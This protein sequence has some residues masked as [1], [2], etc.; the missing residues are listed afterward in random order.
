MTEQSLRGHLLLSAPHMQDPNFMHTV[1][2]ICQHDE[3]GAFG[4]TVNRVG[5]VL[6]RDIFPD[7]PVLKDLKLSLIHI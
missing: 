6:V 4:M 3:N 1:V 5:R 7:A 2:L